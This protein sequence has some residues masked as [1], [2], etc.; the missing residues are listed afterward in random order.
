MSIQQ[1]Q[2]SHLAAQRFQFGFWHGQ[3]RRQHVPAADTLEMQGGLQRGQG[4]AQ[5]SAFLV[6]RRHFISCAGSPLP[7]PPSRPRRAASQNCWQMSGTR[8][9]TLGTMPCAPCRRRTP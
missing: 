2:L 8:L 6:E 9:P 5:R 3:E 4:L 7:P 1:V